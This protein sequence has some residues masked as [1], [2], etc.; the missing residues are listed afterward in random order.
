VDPQFNLLIKAGG[1]DGEKRKIC[2]IKFG[3]AFTKKKFIKPPLKKE[4]RNIHLYSIIL[5]GLAVGMGE[6][7][8]L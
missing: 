6:N 5:S 8:L 2:N 1:G 7:L 4:L 3:Y